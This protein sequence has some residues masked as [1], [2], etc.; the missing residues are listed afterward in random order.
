MKINRL[1]LFA[2]F[3][4]ILLFGM[5]AENMLVGHVPLEFHSRNNTSDAKKQIVQLGMHG[6]LTQIIHPLCKV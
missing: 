5:N 3:V 1:A 4:C 6:R 2:I